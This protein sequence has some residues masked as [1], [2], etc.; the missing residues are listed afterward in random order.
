MP[1][2]VSVILFGFSLVLWGVVG[3]SLARHVT[4][5]GTGIMNSAAAACLVLAGIGLMLEHMLRGSLDRLARDR[6]VRYL[7]DA[8]AFSRRGAVAV[9]A[10]LRVV[11]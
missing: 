7:A 9:T 6:A 1:R 10:P 5:P 11:R 3:D 8:A 2:M 4:L